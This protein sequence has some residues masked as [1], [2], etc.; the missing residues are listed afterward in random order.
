VASSSLAQAGCTRDGSGGWAREAATAKA[1]GRLRARAEAAAKILGLSF[2]R[3]QE[4]RLDNARPAP[5]P[6]FAGA[7]MAMAAPVAEAADVDVTA[8]VEAD[9]VLK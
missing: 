7:A 1:L 9:A 5:M 4:V 6:R 2:D 3:F 8:T